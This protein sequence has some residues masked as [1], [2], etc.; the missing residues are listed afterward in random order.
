MVFFTE[1]KST[2]CRCCVITVMS[3]LPRSN[4]SDAPVLTPSLESPFLPCRDRLS[5]CRPLYPLCRSRSPSVR[6]ASPQPPRNLF[7]NFWHCV[8]RS[9]EDYEL[10][11]PSGLHWNWRACLVAYLCYRVAR[12]R[13]VEPLL[14]QTINQ[15]KS[16]IFRLAQL[17]PFSADF[18]FSG[19]AG[20][21]TISMHLFS[22]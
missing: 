17:I 12:K 11:F 6:P 15:W 4:C 7:A 18:T 9:L 2:F 16:R 1:S 8:T 13:I 3:Q 14:Q 10:I 5:P 22:S 21:A 20:L 19:T